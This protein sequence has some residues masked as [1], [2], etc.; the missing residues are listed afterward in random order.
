MR[1]LVRINSG[2]GKAGELKSEARLEIMHRLKNGMGFLLLLG[3]TWLVGYFTVIEQLNLAVHVIFI[4]LNSL[5][6]FFIFVFY[7]LRQPQSRARLQEHL[8]CCFHDSSL[9]TDTGLMG[10]K[11]TTVTGTENPYNESVLS[12]SD[13]DEHVSGE[14]E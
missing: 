6:G 5:Q 4:L 1:R 12:K 3:L 14:C 2:G 10:M 13:N 7:V 9:T 11:Q 8:G